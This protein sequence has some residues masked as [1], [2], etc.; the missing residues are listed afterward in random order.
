M[1]FDSCSLRHNRSALILLTGSSGQAVVEFTLTFLLLLVV[2][3]IPADFGLAFYTGN[4][5]ITRHAKEPELPLRI[6]H[7]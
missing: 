5:L 7:S 2:A 6:L 4:L 1:S 3:W